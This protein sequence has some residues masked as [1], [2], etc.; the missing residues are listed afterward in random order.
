LHAERAHG[1]RE[2]LLDR[3]NGDKGTMRHVMDD[4]RDER[5]ESSPNEDSDINLRKASR[6][7]L[8]FRIKRTTPRCKIT[9]TA[10][11]FVSREQEKTRKKKNRYED[12]EKVHH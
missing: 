3:T 5:A 4:A 6:P 10:L 9:R 12:E 8:Y 7:T 11:G 2:E 1:T